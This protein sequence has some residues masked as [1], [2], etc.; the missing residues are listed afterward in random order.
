LLGF[1]HLLEEPKPGGQLFAKAGRVLQDSG[2]TLKIGL[3][4]D[5]TLIAAPGLT[6][7]AKQERDPEMHQPRK[8]R[9][10]MGKRVASTVVDDETGMVLL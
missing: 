3:I 10:Y 6:K 9:H 4:V 2:M 5:A 7:N 1:R 8:G